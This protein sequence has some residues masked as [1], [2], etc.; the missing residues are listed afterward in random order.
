MWSI[1]ELAAERKSF[2]EEYASY[3]VFHG[4]N[5]GMSM[6]D[7]VMFAMSNT[8]PAWNYLWWI[9]EDDARGI[10]RRYAMLA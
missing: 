6:E 7:C 1:A 2:A 4:H 8:E 10:C 3:V 9:G 5:E